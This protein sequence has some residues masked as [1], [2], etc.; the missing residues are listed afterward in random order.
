[1]NR[2]FAALSDLNRLRIISI[3]HKGPLN[4]SEICS[5]LGLSQSN[6]SRHL[7][8]LH[9]A[10]LVSRRG[11]A[12]WAWYSL[13]RTDPLVRDAC[14]LV[15]AHGGRLKVVQ[16]DLRGLVRC[17]ESRRAG[18]REFFA[19]FAPLW[20]EL[21]GLLPDPSGYAGEVIGC[22]PANAPVAELGCGTGMLLPLL[23][24]GG[25]LVI[26][27]DDSPD[28]LS[29]ARRTADD[30]G[31]SD[32]VELRLGEIEHLPLADGSVKG[33]LAHM[34]LHHLGNPSEGIREAWRALEPGGSLVVAELASHGDQSLREL[35]GD[36]WPGFEPEDISG[37]MQECGFEC[38]EARRVCDGRVF[39]ICGR[40]KES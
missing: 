37:M 26:G 30:A 9:E 15:A 23:V 34:V 28:M 3:L 21:S 31:L 4:V 25:R 12:G 1:M 38:G 32:R 35:H 19:R 24:S 29:R 36:L 22:L 39:Y 17:H 16:D 6:A 14:A 20:G 27:I 11:M 10:G 40:R 18:S 8:A 7:K 33:V 5:V 2:V 13:E